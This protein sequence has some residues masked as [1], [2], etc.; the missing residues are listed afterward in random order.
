MSSVALYLPLGIIP[1]QP[2]ILWCKDSKN[3]TLFSLLMSFSMFF[4]LY[5]FH[6]L[7]YRQRY[8]LQIFYYEVLWQSYTW[9]G[10]LGVFVYTNIQR[11]P[12]I[13]SN[14]PCSVKTDWMCISYCVNWNSHFLY[15]FS[16]VSVLRGICKNQDLGM[17]TKGYLLYKKLEEW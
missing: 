6:H 12:F 2:F 4:P 14:T 9:E 7:V 10:F 13:F 1:S 5:N 17:S 3:I 15:S 16:K 8:W 11:A